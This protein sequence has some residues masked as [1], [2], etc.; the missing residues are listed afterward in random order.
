MTERDDERDD[1]PTAHGVQQADDDGPPACIVG[2]PFALSYDCELSTEIRPGE[3]PNVVVLCECG[4]LFRLLLLEP[5][6]KPCPHCKREYTHVLLV[7]AAKNDQAFNGVCE[8][9]ADAN[10]ADGGGGD[11]EEGDDE[12]GDDE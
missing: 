11:D 12:E 6:Y 3:G 7:C 2:E 4:K 9:I 1:V 5:G 8:H 10:D